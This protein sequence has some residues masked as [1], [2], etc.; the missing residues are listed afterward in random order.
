M[1]I[2][3]LFRKKQNQPT[4]QPDRETITAKDA[5]KLARGKSGNGYN[6]F[7]SIREKATAGRLNVYVNPKKLSPE[8]IELLKSE[9]YNFKVREVKQGN[10]ISHYSIEW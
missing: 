10:E 4:P 9:P 3:H 1:A 2:H 8:D 7:D 5:R 6:V